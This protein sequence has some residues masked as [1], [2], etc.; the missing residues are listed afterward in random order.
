MQNVTEFVTFAWSS[1]RAGSL[2]QA[3]A[4]LVGASLLAMAVADAKRFTLYS[5]RPP[6]HRVLEFRHAP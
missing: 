3:C 1:S 6:P 5:S 4:G 2:P